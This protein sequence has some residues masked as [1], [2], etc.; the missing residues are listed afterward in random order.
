M[1][2]KAIQGAAGACLMFLA[3]SMP[4]AAAEHKSLLFP[5][6]HFED[7]NKMVWVESTTSFSDHPSNNL[8]ETVLVSGNTKVKLTGES[9][10]GTARLE[11]QGKTWYADEDTLTDKSP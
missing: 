6:Y 7:M 1:I 9:G 4:A 3:G 2:K 11:Y 5:Q 10:T 8:G